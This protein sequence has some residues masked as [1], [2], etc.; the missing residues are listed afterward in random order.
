MS[1]TTEC[2]D[3]LRDDDALFTVGVFREGEEKNADDILMRRWL[4]NK[5]FPLAVDILM[6][7]WLSNNFFPLAAR[8]LLILPLLHQHPK[9][10]FI[11]CT[12]L[13]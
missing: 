8:R 6:R 5:F 2:D 12:Y 10:A 7:R 4:S 13:N 9:K 11:L 1:F 3:V